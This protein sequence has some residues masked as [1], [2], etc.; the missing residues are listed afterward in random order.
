MPG[1][2]TTP[3]A[4]G[5]PSKYRN[6]AGWMERRDTTTRGKPHKR[7]VQQAA[8][9]QFNSLFFLWFDLGQGRCGVQYSNFT[10]ERA[11]ERWSMGVAWHGR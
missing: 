3:P 9:V 8:A 6:T 7:D 5:Q 4:N 2:R 11:S 1:V 10:G